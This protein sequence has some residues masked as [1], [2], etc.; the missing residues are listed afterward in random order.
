MA[1]ALPLNLLAMGALSIA[2]AEPRRW[3]QYVAKL[4]ELRSREKL[5]ERNYVLLR[6]SLL[7]RSILLTTT[8]GDPDALSEDTADYVMK[9]ALAEH[10][11]EL[12][13]EIRQREEALV[14]G[15]EQ[16]RA[17]EA[18]AAEAEAARHDREREQMAAFTRVARKNAR[19]VVVIAGFTLAVLVLVASVISFPWPIEPPLST[20][21]PAWLSIALGVVAIAIGTASVVVGSTIHGVGE[22]LIDGLT[23]V[24]ARRYKS[25]FAPNEDVAKSPIDPV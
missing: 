9:H 7:A 18:K 3:L 2:E 21:L 14:T 15:A 10:T 8:D 17:S 25:R 23:E 16:L 4:D 5:P 20:V 24:L 11:R 19:R 6:Q 13:Q 22:K 1:D 12:Q